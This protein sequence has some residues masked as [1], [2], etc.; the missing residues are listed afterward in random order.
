MT[1][2]NC[3]RL[4]ASL[5]VLTLI[6]AMGSVVSASNPMEGAGLVASAGTNSQPQQQNPTDSNP[7]SPVS[8]TYRGVLPV[9][10]FDVSPPLRSIAPLPGKPGLEREIEELEVPNSRAGQTHDRDPILQSLLGPL[11]IPTPIISFDGIANLCNC[12]VPDANGEVGRDHYVSM[13]NFH[14]QIF[15][16]SGTSLYGPAANNTLWYGFGGICETDSGIDPIVLYDQLADRW[17]LTQVTQLPGSGPPFYHCVALS[18]SPDPTGTYYRWAFPTGGN[19]PD[20][21]KFGMWPNAYFISAKEF[22]GTTFVGI[23]ISAANRAQMLAGNPNPQLISYIL[24][25]GSMPYNVS[26]GLLPADLDGMTPPP[27][28]NPHYFVGSMDNDHSYGAPQDALTLWKFV[29]DFANPPNSSFTLAKT[30]PMQPFDTLLSTCSGRNCI[31]QRDTTNKLDHLGYRQRPLFRL[32]YRNFGTYEALVTNQSVEGAPGVS[33]IRWWELR[34]PNNDP[35]IFQE[36]TFAPGAIDGIHRWMGSIA[37]NKRGDMAL[38]Y[39]ASNSAIFPGIRYTGRLVSDPPG[40]MSLGEGSIK[41]GTGSL[42]GIQRWGDYT[43]MT[44]DPVDDCTFWYTNQYV[45]TTSYN[46]WQVRIGAFRYPGCVE[47]SPGPTA[48]ST[49]G[50]PATPTA[51]T[52]D[53]PFTDVDQNNPFYAYIKCLYCRGIVSGFGDNTFRPNNN[54]TRGQMSKILSNAAGFN[55]PVSGQRYTDVPPTHT[56]YM[57]I[58]RLAQRSIATGYANP[59]DCPTGAPCFRPEQPITRGQMAKIASNAAGFE[60]EPPPG[61]LSFTDVPSSYTFYVYIERLARRGVISGYP[62]GGAGEQCDTDRRPYYRPGANISRGQA[63]K[64]VSNTFFPSNCAPGTP[65]VIPGK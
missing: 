63:S 38:G 57:Y 24:P 1:R 33:G 10:R 39:S 43:G 65:P 60:D 14:F 44:V 9:E 3:L 50:P 21:P 55:E 23:G 7:P 61:T 64:I 31:P 49:I 36:G 52:C 18:T 34:S 16:K 6:W 29:V 58:E 56:F 53:M 20:Y 27:A 26:D 30:L 13:I 8:G 11:A 22:A 12:L 45:P 19:Y 25:P 54:I 59:A 40:Q 46:G 35:I 15:D 17:L 32:A 42:T 5:F 48:T 47:G 62:C 37:Q 4:I 2:R 51:P 28:N 41:E